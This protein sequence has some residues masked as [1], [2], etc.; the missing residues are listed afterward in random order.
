MVVVA[1]AF[2][3]VVIGMVV[4]AEMVVGTAEEVEII[5][6]IEETVVVSTVEISIDVVNV[7][8]VV[9]ST[10]EVLAAKLG[11]FWGPAGGLG[12][13]FNDCIGGF[14]SSSSTS[15]TGPQTFFKRPLFARRTCSA[16]PAK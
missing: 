7:M 2:R 11:Q 12:G 16:D 5:E 3:V 14:S 15:S 1:A 9:D 13:G 10:V 4:A 6:E 8:E